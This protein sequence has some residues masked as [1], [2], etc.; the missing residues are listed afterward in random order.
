M[1]RYRLEVGHK[2]EVKPGNIVGAIANEAGLESKHIGRIDIHDDFSVVDLPSGMP[3]DIFNTLK[4]TWVSGTQLKIS[5]LDSSSELTD[6]KN[7]AARK[8]KAKNKLKSKSRSKPKNKDGVKR[9]RKAK[10]N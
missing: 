6:S 7:S 2:H 9:K 1:E 10:V 5:I 4:K 8:L 3:K